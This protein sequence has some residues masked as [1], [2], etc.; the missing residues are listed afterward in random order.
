MA[1]ATTVWVDFDVQDLDQVMPEGVVRG[2]LV[3][4]S[5]FPT[6]KGETLTVEL[7]K[8]DSL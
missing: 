4:E 5:A 2:D 3:I 7:V 8:A 6:N 1:E